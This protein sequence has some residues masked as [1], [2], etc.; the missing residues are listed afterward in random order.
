MGL[1]CISRQR[2]II[3]LFLSAAQRRAERFLGVGTACL[4]AASMADSNRPK[5]PKTYALKATTLPAGSR[6]STIAWT[7]SPHAASA[8]RFSSAQS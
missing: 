2:C 5:A 4:P 8:A 7:R 6:P 1:G 3:A